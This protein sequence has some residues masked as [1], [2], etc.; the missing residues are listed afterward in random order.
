M[1]TPVNLNTAT[2]DELETL[3][4]IGPE[5]AQNVVY[6]REKH[7]AFESVEHLARV[8][9]IG[10]RTLARLRGLVTV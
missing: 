2:A 10:P 4:Y 1:N 6:Y 3:P 7:G 5:K 9:G 8:S